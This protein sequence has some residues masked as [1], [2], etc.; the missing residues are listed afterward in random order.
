MDMQSPLLQA[1]IALW[2]AKV[3]NGRDNSVL[4]R[5]DFP[6]RHISLGETPW[7][8]VPTGR[9]PCVGTSHTYV[10][11]LGRYTRRHEIGI[12]MELQLNE[13]ELDALRQV[14]DSAIG[15]LSSEI[16]DTDN[17]TYRKGL[18]DYRDALRSISSRIAP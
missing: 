2:A 17:P 18:N 6:W 9:G 1:R 12:N 14:L 3:T 15:D 16:A 5:I 13:Q 7:A 4:H 11:R 10:D 8:S